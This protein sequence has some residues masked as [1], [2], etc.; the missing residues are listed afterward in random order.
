M[1][2][3]INIAVSMCIFPFFHFHMCVYACLHV[4]R[5]TCVCTWMWVPMHV[6]A[7]LISGTILSASSILFIGSGSLN[8]TQSRSIWTVLPDCPFP[9]FWN[10]R[11]VTHPGLFILGIGTLGFHFRCKSPS[12]PQANFIQASVLLSA[13]TKLPW[14]EPQA[15]PVCEPGAS[16]QHLSAQ[17]RSNNSTVFASVMIA[18]TVR[19][20]DR[21][22]QWIFPVLLP[23]AGV[24]E[25]T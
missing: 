5:H 4:C 8:Q 7:W 12:S 15:C 14:L 6:E 9:D 13:C 16:P 21:Q 18:M 22:I 20:E 2:E 10:Y 24:S 19:G 3:F 11:R 1:V 23:W 25:Q 17:S